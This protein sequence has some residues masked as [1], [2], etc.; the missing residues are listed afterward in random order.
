M[1]EIF[2]ERHWTM[3]AVEDAATAV[4]ALKHARP[5]AALLDVRPSGKRSGWDVLEQLQAEPDTRTIPVVIWSGDGHC[6][7]EK[8]AW[9]ADHRIRLLP[10]PFDLDELYACLDQALDARQT[11]RNGCVTVPAS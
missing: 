2:A 4:A 3:L 10:K 8:R 6:L 11:P 9:L 5:D 1:G 7:D